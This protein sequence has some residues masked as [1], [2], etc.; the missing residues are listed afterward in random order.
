MDKSK[1]LKTRISRLQKL[2]SFYEYLTD[3]Y[4]LRVCLDGGVEK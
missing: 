2:E 1:L 4:R 3:F